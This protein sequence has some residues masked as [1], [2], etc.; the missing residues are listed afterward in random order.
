M[1][2]PENALRKDVRQRPLHINAIQLP[3]TPA[4]CAPM[5]E[6]IEPVTASILHSTIEQDAPIR[7]E[8]I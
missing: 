7:H 3:T 5:A 8:L 1:L 6:R 2:K 4:R